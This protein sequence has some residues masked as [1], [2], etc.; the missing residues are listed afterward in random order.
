M[1]NEQERKT[2]NF[3]EREARTKKEERRKKYE[4]KQKTK[5]DKDEVLKEFMRKVGNH[6]E[7]EIGKGEFVPLTLEEVHKKL[8]TLITRT[9][10]ALEA[11][12]K[13]EEKLKR[14]EKHY[15]GK[16]SNGLVE[17]LTEEVIR[18]QKEAN[19]AKKAE[20]NMTRFV[21]GFEKNGAQIVKIYNIEQRTIAKKQRSLR[22]AKNALSGKDGINEKLKIIKNNENEIKKIREQQS[23]IDKELENL[24]KKVGKT[25]TG[26]EM[27]EEQKQERAADFARSKVLAEQKI[28]IE[29]QLKEKQSDKAILEKSKLEEKAKALKETIKMYESG[30]SQE[31]QVIHKCK[32]ARQLLLAGKS[33]DDIERISIEELYG[34]Q[35]DDMKHSKTTSSTEIKPQPIS[36]QN[37]QPIQRL[38]PERKEPAEIV[39]QPLV[40]ANPHPILSKIPLVGKVASKFVDGFMAGTRKVKDLF[41]KKDSQ[42]DLDEDVSQEKSHSIPEPEI[43]P[44]TEP[45]TKPQPVQTAR[46]PQEKTKESIKIKRDRFMEYLREAVEEGHTEQ[47]KYVTSKPKTQERQEKNNTQK[48]QEDLSERN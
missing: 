9:D 36:K 22:D 38:D 42:T 46:I 21:E 6:S 35:L 31:D 48:G 30:K 19:A 2:E 40:P 13:A 11:Q 26:E 7:Q 45:E 28:A 34:K 10:D 44:E 14:V 33:W 3:L 25:W 8:K 24:A 17:K 39:L 37:L 20:K 18:L 32:L 5:V 43:K 41:M 29:K 15:K 12:I 23:K 4:V 27:T 16:D 47:G 1:A